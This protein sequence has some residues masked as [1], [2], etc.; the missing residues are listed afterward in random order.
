M[1]QY[2][3][4]CTVY[5]LALSGICNLTEES[6][7]L[8]RYEGGGEGLIKSKYSVISLSLRCLKLAL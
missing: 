3:I 8:Q 1:K 4:H 7:N 5:Q 2:T 6:N